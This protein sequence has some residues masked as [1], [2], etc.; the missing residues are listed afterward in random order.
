MSEDTG[1]TGTEPRRTFT[2][3]AVRGGGLN[4]GGGGSG[5]FGSARFASDGGGGRGND[6]VVGGNRRSVT[7]RFLGWVIAKLRVS[8][9]S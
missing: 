7:R 5:F 2:G 4:V 3:V 6:F 8:S 1:I 9:M